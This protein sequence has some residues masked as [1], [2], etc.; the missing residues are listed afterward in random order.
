[1]EIFRPFGAPV[2]VEKVDYSLRPWINLND[3]PLV[4][5]YSDRTTKELYSQKRS[6]IL[7]FVADSPQ[8]QTLLA[9]FKEAAAEWKLAQKKKLIFAQISVLL[10]VCRPL[11]I[12]RPTLASRITSR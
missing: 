3:R 12:L 4:F 11:L 1:V 2:L 10:L 9:S 6:G 8:G 5:D 7:L